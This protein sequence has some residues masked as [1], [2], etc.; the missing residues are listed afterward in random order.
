MITEIDMT[1]SRNNDPNLH[2]PR[3]L[4]CA[5]LIALLLLPFAPSHTHAQSEKEAIPATDQFKSW[6]RKYRRGDIHLYEASPVPLARGTG[7]AYR[8][9]KND[10]LKEMDRHLDG[11]A[12]R[13]DLEAVKLLVEA[14]IFRFDRRPDREM[15]KFSRQQP[16]VL[17]AHALRALKRITSDE[18]LSWLRR[19]CLAAEVGWDAPF[20]K[21]IAAQVFGANRGIED[22]ETTT[23]LLADRDPR[24]RV[25][26]LNALAR[27]GTSE[28]MDRVKPLLED[29]EKEVRVAALQ[30][31]AG[32]IT[33]RD[34]QSR[35]SEEEAN[36]CLAIAVAALDDSEW[37]VQE[38]A[39][40]LI[41]RFRSVK[42]VPILIDRLDRMATRTGDYRERI[43]QRTCEVLRSLTGA[44]IASVD[45][46]PWKKWWT[47]YGPTFRMA[48]APSPT[49]ARIPAHRGPFLQHSRVLRLRLLYPRYFGKHGESPTH[50]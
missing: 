49:P 4:T 29:P 13:N 30:A 9:H 40:T 15:A 12:R 26:T 42:S 11:L 5:L 3:L 18:G 35:P 1:T 22:K 16:W 27:T 23:R 6:F 38:A 33:P 34:G 20:R 24:V 31:M 8:F 39:L 28:D 32:L 44:Q 21:V 2:S 17:R 43:R 48:P 41:E 47:E 14:A 25:E 7:S 46:P 36:R 19:R 50:P 45:S 10:A 37:S